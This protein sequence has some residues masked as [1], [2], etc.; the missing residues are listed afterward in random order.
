MVAGGMMLLPAAA[1]GLFFAIRSA[2]MLATNAAGVP[3]RQAAQTASF[4]PAP[5]NPKYDLEPVDTTRPLAGASLEDVVEFVKHGI[6]KIETSDGLNNRR[7]L[8]SGFVID[9]SGLVATNYHVMSDAA[10]ADVI[11]NDGTRFGVDGYMAVD[12]RSDLAILRLNG[13]PPNVKAVALNYGDGPRDAAQVYAIG[14]PLDNEFTTT[15][16][17]VGRVLRTTQ[18]PGET[19]PL[20]GVDARRKRRRS[21]DSA[22]RQDRTGQQR[23][24]AHQRTR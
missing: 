6:V 18:L 4:N 17:I 21:L 2:G 19:P 11:F 24:P 8:G 7:G 9:P 22:R 12:R 3:T 23:R 14:H 1:G 16:G 13:V 15:G 20:A 10:K 5:F